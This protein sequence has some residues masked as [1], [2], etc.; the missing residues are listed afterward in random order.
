MTEKKIS[1]TSK[2]IR[3]ILHERNINRGKKFFYPV[4]KN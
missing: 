3:E 4:N 1:I 2:P